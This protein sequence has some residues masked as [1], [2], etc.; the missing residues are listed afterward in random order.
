MIAALSPAGSDYEETMSTLQFAQHVKAVKTNA[1]KNLI[2]ED[3]VLQELEAEC[4]RLRHLVE[5][6]A[7]DGRL[8]SPASVVD[9]T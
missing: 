3:H 1:K 7:G 9:R 8:Y 4:A 5:T 2:K 6:G